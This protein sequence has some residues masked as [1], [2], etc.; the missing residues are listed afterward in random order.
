MYISRTIHGIYTKG[1]NSHIEKYVDK[2]EYLKFTTK[3]THIIPIKP[4]LYH[5]IN[6]SQAID[7][8]IKSI[9]K[10]RKTIDGR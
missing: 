6:K 2:Q 10:N 5:R 8:Q 3:E 9:Q 4:H 1:V 7:G